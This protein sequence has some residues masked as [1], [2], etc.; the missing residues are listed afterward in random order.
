MVLSFNQKGQEVNLKTMSFIA[1]IVNVT[2]PLKIFVSKLYNMT[3]LQITTEAKRFGLGFS[4][5]TH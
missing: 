1:Y 4:K 2:I 3:S 5:F